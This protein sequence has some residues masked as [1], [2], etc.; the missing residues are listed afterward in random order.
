MIDK[1]YFAVVLQS[2]LIQIRAEIMSDPKARLEL[3]IQQEYGESEAM[4][5]FERMVKRYGWN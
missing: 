4:A 5:A 2:I 1:V 3:G